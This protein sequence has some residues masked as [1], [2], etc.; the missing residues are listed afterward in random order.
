MTWGLFSQRQEDR[1]A[2]HLKVTLSY[3]IL[4]P[5]IWKYVFRHVLIRF[6]SPIDVIKRRKDPTMRL[7][8]GFSISCL[9]LFTCRRKIWRRNTTKNIILLIILSLW[10]H[11]LSVGHLAFVS[12][13]VLVF[14]RRKPCPSLYFPFSPK[15]KRQG[16]DLFRFQGTHWSH[17]C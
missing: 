12:W 2:W 11:I 4:V 7:N 13:A 5:N 17:F 9:L 1:L 16:F 10:S 14:G 6:I 3:V 8:F 15:E